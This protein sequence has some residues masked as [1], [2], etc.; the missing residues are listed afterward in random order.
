MRAFPIAAPLLLL[1]AL[2]SA[3]CKK[4]QVASATNPAPLNPAGT[5]AD[6]APHAPVD[7]AA[8]FTGKV[9]RGERYTRSIAPN[10]I[11]RLEPD[12]GNDS[13]WTI[14]MIPGTD[15]KDQS[16]D[17]IGAVSEPLHNNRNLYIDA[18]DSAAQ[19]ETPA[20]KQHEFDFVPDAS[21]CR[22]A[23]DLMNSVYYASKLTD[24][25][26]AEAGEKLGRIPTEHVALT[27]V[28]SRLAPAPDS[29]DPP[30]IEWLKFDAALDMPP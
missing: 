25:Q 29:S 20:W 16:I 6:A 5:P 9:R 14:R 3:A 2:V 12:A 22:I 30:I 7:T 15:P 1:V 23:W 17:C 4:P 21:N 8:H 28:D 18:P 11:F 27:I 26:R 10:M 24:E 13:G 19:A